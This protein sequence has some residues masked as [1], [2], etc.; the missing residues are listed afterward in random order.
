[1]LRA[2]IL[3]FGGNWEDY[4]YLAEFAYNNSYQSTIGMASFEALYGKPC[5]SPAC[6]MEAGEGVLL[7]PENVKK[8]LQELN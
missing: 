5:L 7:G 4:L 8:L 6:W 3:D 2:C 1:M